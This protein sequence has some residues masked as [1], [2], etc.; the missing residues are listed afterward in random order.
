MISGYI[1]WNASHSAC[2]H[3]ICVMA[4]E[5]QMNHCCVVMIV[6]SFSSVADHDLYNTQ[7]GYKPP[8]NPPGKKGSKA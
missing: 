6:C 1:K 7:D 8:D 4:A 3:I 5:I 2:G